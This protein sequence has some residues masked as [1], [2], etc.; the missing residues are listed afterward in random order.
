MQFLERWKGSRVATCHSIVDLTLWAMLFYQPVV[1][2]RYESLQSINVELY[3]FLVLYQYVY[4]L[5]M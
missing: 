1:S 3:V 2:T 4:I 5:E